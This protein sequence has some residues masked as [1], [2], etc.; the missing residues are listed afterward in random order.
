MKTGSY[1]VATKMTAFLC[2]LFQ[3]VCCRGATFSLNPSADAFVTTGPGGNLAT[4]NYGGAGALSVAAPGLAQGEFQSVMQFGFSAAKSSF[5]SQFGS[6]QWSIQS[7]T[8]Q[9]TAAT[10]NNAIFNPSSAGHFNV[11][12]MQNNGWSEGSG[13]PMAPGSTGITFSSLSSFVG[14]ADEMLGTFS[15]NGAT[16][17][18]ATYTLNLSSSLAAD[19]L[20]GGTASFRLFAADS[21]I[22]YLFDSRNFSMASARPL[23]DITAVPE[24]GILALGMFG[25][26]LI[27]RRGLFKEKRA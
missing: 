18:A 10:P 12:L 20:A 27:S 24:P 26:G 22:S 17:G 23:L 21:S 4:N 6:G 13:T 15:F 7:V 11:S 2:F 8:L 14:S 5:D 19:I 16:N 25:L 9:L 3:V 1:C